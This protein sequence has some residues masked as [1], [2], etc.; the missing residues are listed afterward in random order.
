MEMN[1]YSLECHA[2]DVLAAARA[3]SRREA[4]APR[5]PVVRPLLA[6]LA[7]RLCPTRWSPLKTARS[8]PTIARA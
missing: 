5:V 3:T 7:A 6:T 4:L 8:N 1:V 2:R